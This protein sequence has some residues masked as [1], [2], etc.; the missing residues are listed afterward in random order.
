V[1]DFSGGGGSSGGGGASGS[2]ECKEPCKEKKICIKKVPPAPKKWLGT[3]EY[4]IWRY[5]NFLERHQGCGHTP[6]D[7]YIAYGH[8]YCIKFSTE[9]YPKLSEGGKGWLT[10]ARMLLQVYMEDG[11]RRDNS[12]ELDNEGFRKFA[13]GTHP[14][15]YWNAGFKDL[16]IADKIKVAMTPD[17]KEWANAETWLQALDIGKRQLEQWAKDLG[18]IF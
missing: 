5:M 13:F 9:L 8:K 11:L 6:P 7:Y 10:R 18:D 15:A 3:C 16:S 4:Y 12:I 17:W 14:D 1:S 2:W